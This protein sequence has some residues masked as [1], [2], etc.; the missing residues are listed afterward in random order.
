MLNPAFAVFPTNKIKNQTMRGY[1]TEEAR[2][3]RMC[4]YGEPESREDRDLARAWA[5]QETQ[6]MERELREEECR[7]N[8]EGH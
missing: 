8:P 5:R 2:L 1:L 4:E 6:K 7:N 3:E